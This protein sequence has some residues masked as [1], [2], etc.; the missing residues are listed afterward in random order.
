MSNKRRLDVIEEGTD[1]SDYVSFVALGGGNE[2]GRS[3]HIL[4]Y[5]GKTVMLDAG[6]HPA[7][8]GLAALPFYD[9]YDLSTVDILL[10]SHFHLDHA[11]SLPYVMQKTDFRGRVFM[12]HPTK[13]IYKWLLS[14]YVRV[15]NMGSTD[16][17]L[18][19]EKDLVAS[20][21]RIEAV[22]FHSTTEVQGVRF[23]PYHAGHVLGAAMY[24]IEIAGVKVLFTGDYSREED[25]HLNVAELPPLQPDILI[26]ESTYG[27]ALHQPRLEKETRLTHLIHSVIKRG[28]RVLMPMFALGNT[29]EILLI[30]DEY[31][32]AHP[33]LHSIPIYYASA[34]A[35]KCMAVYQTYVN[36]LND[37]IRGQFKERNPFVFRHVN[38]LRS[39][40]RFDDVGPCV[41]LA[42]P[43]MLQNGVSRELLE[44]WAPDGKNAL[45]IAGFS[46]E[47]TMAKHILSEP[48]EIQTM[49]GQKVPRRMTIEEISF[50]AHVDYAQN[51]SFIESV[52]ARNIVSAF[53]Y[54][55]TIDSGAW[56]AKQYGEAEE[57][58]VEQVC[59]SQGR[60]G[61]SEDFQPA[62]LR[63]VKDAF[64]GRQSSPCDGRHCQKVTG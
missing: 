20:F 11:A 48:S 13:A 17:Q 29:Q 28:G 15:S 59:G 5:K 39:L 6:V 22:D 4:E 1:E 55:L 64:L 36:M 54:P 46:V 34:L 53:H 37:H 12:T 41:M 61:P 25:R 8:N 30:L 50:A 31:W 27:T 10:I 62:E 23:T 9:E 21:E 47:G 43:G 33:E 57:Q 2:V 60:Q 26:T 16:D 42:S 51:S 63:D 24:F 56:R 14:D 3:C 7:Y 58:I 49:N 18:Y 35:R 19:D 52:N 38:S 44:R 40:D 45:I 32:H